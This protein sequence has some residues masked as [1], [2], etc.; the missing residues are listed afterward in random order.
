MKLIDLAILAIVA[1]LC[2]KGIIAYW[3]DPCSG[4]GKNC[5]NCALRKIENRTET[6]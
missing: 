4:C 1:L 6:L 3:K 5:E 2:I